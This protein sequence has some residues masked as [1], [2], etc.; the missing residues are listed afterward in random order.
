MT[1]Q[2]AH[3]DHFLPFLILNAEASGFSMSWAEAAARVRT[4][5]ALGLGFLHEEMVTWF[6]VAG[7]AL[8]VPAGGEVGGEDKMTENSSPLEPRNATSPSALEAAL[9]WL[10]RP[11]RHPILWKHTLMAIKY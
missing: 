3:G 9:S 4:D 7:E 1:K 5:L 8:Q 11:E 10:E 6:T 2:G